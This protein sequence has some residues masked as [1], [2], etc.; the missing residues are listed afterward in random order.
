MHE[1]CHYGLSEDEI[2]FES[3]CRAS[4]II[5]ILNKRTTQV[6]EY[7]I[8][9][10]NQSMTSYQNGVCPKRVRADLWFIPIWSAKS[11]T[12]FSNFNLR[13]IGNWRL[14]LMAIYKCWFCMLWVAAAFPKSGNNNNKKKRRIPPILFINHF[15]HMPIEWPNVIL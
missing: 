2:Q 1:N 9:L 12:Q 10:K 13:T 4:R 3:E 14:C 11:I 8:D 15:G 5:Y 7:V 6:K